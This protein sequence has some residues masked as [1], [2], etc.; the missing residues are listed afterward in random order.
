MVLDGRSSQEFPVNA[1]FPQGFILGPT[2]F[3]IYGLD[4]VICNTAIYT[5]DITR[6]S[7]CDQAS[8][9]WEQLELASELESDQQVS[10]DQSN[11]TGADDVI[12]DGSALF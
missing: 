3:L 12:T 4:D 9:L 1:G 10:F 2:F 11:N 7:R 6:Y 8:D 5:D